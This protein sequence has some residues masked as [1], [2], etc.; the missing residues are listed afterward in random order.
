R[1]LLSASAGTYGNTNYV[2]DDVAHE[3]PSP[4]QAFAAVTNALLSAG[5]PAGAIKYWY[6][7]EYCLIWSNNFVANAIGIPAPGSNCI[8]YIVQPHLTNALN[9]AGYISWGA[10]S[11]LENDYA[12]GGTNGVKVRW[13]GNSGWW[14][15]QTLE[16]FNGLP[17]GGQGN[18]YQWF[19]NGA[20]G[21]FR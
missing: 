9:V 12:L 19:C 17:A 21:G 14:I 16:S 2:I 20:F 4:T 3:N 1:L 18:F 6:T 8:S 7:N 15:I 11:S 13:Q 10:H 5:A